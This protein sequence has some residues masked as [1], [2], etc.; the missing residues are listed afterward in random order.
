MMLINPFWKK[1]TAWWLDTPFS[2]VT[3]LNNLVLNGVQLVQNGTGLTIST[4]NDANGALYLSGSA[5]LTTSTPKPLMDKDFNIS[6]EVFI[7]TG[8]DTYSVFLAQRVDSYYSDTE[9]YSLL[10]G[11]LWVVTYFSDDS[12]ETFTGVAIR[13]QWQTVEMSR[14][15]S[16][17]SL[18]V[19]GVV[20]ESK[21]IN[22][23]IR[24]LSSG[25]FNI[26]NANQTIG[27]GTCT[28]SMRNLYIQVAD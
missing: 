9:F 19:D 11:R 20:A 14:V 3:Q 8:S 24:N 6:C 1:H 4:T 15:G 23:T 26:G 25:T 28:G 2:T 12:V 7:A 16:T 10:D 27:S 18:K 17:F 21:T 22:K 13:N 5:W